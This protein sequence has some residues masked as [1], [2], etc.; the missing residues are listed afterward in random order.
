MCD[1]GNREPYPRFLSQDIEALFIHWLTFEKH[2]SNKTLCET[3]S[4]CSECF[5]IK[6]C[7]DVA[8]M[9]QLHCTIRSW[10]KMLKGSNVASLL[11][12]YMTENEARTIYENIISLDPDSSDY[13]KIAKIR[14]HEMFN[15]FFPSITHKNILEISLETGHYLPFITHCC[16]Q[17][18]TLAVRYNEVLLNTKENFYYMIIFVLLSFHLNGLLA[19]SP[20]IITY[21]WA[22]TF[23]ESV[24]AWFYIKTYFEIKKKKNG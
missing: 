18:K 1:Q 4:H 23:L 24:I 22:E 11:T 19:F 17:F 5:L 8:V 12:G 15:T 16:V 10:E 2:H 21:M 13:D 9:K 6:D 14:I 20:D 3:I 7:I